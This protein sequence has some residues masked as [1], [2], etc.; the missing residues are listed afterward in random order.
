MLIPSQLVQYLLANPLHF[1]LTKYSP[2]MDIV[3]FWIILSIIAGVF[4]GTKGR[5][6]FG[7]FLI[8]C[9]LSPVI[10]LL[11]IAILPTNNFENIIVH[12]S[13][14]GSLSEIKNLLERGLITQEEYDA[15]RK[16]I[17]ESID[18]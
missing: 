15:R 14:E 4:A 1:A 18:S 3:I 17:I 12:N 11:L 5:S 8:S 16:V 7:W 13:L 10:G 6:G 9:L 2:D